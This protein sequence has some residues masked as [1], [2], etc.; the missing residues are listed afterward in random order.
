MVGREPVQLSLG[1]SGAIEVFKH[2]LERVVDNLVL[3]KQF[4]KRNLQKLYQITLLQLARGDLSLYY[5]Y[6]VS[7]V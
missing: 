6:A 7:T 4:R 3:V 5:F 2:Y 1:P